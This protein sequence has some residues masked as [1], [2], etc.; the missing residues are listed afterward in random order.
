MLIVSSWSEQFRVD[1]GLKGFSQVWGGPPAWYI[2]LVD[3][4]GVY[5]LTLLETEEKKHKGKD[6]RKA[7]FAVKCYP[8]PD[9]TCYSSFAF[10][11]QELIQS[12]FFDETNTPVFECRE[13]IP[14]DLFNIA[15]LEI[16]MDDEANMARFCIETL[17]ILRSRYASKTDQIFP[18]L[19]IARKFVMDEI[20]RDIPGLEIAY[21]L[22]DCLMCLYANAG[23]QAPIQVQCSK[24]PGLEVVI[25]RGKVSAKP[26]KAITGYRL[27]VLYDAADCHEQKITEPMQ[28][29]LGEYAEAPFY[30]RIFP[31]GHFHDEEVDGNLP[32][33]INK[34]WWSLAHRHYAS[35]LASSCGCH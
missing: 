25:E 35:E 19:D 13:K 28:I 22:F 3:A 23:K 9:D 1:I 15:I 2:W 33:T 18:V 32:I 31:C 8:Y 20:D 16:T 30:K 4:P 29:E 14:S 6:F 11:E 12:R 27:D 34:N 24:T 26:N 7:V 21:P 10:I 17:D 5:H